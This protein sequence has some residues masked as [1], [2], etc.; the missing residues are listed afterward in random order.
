MFQ[1]HVFPTI[2]SQQEKGL[3]FTTSDNLKDVDLERRTIMTLGTQKLQNKKGNQALCLTR[4]LC[5]L[6]CVFSFYLAF[7]RQTTEKQ[8]SGRTEIFISSRRELKLSSWPQNSSLFPTDKLPLGLWYYRKN[9]P[10]MAD[11]EQGNSG[12]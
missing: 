8:H 2:K 3:Y 10:A 11:P 9:I 1:P 4:N 6:F 7:L 5:F 12:A